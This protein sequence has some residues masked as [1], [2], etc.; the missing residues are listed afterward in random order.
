MKALRP[1]RAAALAAVLLSA[2]MLAAPLPSQAATERGLIWRVSRDG[3]PVSFLLG[4]IHVG[5]PDMYPLPETMRQAY[6]RSDALVVE[7]DIV[8]ADMGRLSS[9]V[10]EKGTYQDGGSLKDAVDPGA[11][12]DIRAAADRYG[13]PLSLLRDQKPWLAYS[14]LTLLAVQAEGYSERYGVDRHFL[15][16]A[17]KDH[18][19]VV[20][21]EGVERQLQVLADMAADQQSALLAYTAGQIADGAVP[22]AEL[23]DAWRS[24]RPAQLQAQV[25]AH[26][27]HSLQGVYDALILRRNR[28][29]V[30]RLRGL[31][32][33]RRRLLVVVG[34]AH[35]T[36][37][38]GL[39][40][41]LRQRGYRVEQM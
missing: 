37:P 3:A 41:E 20:E 23:V 30:E 28:T 38:S 7:A 18:K 9:L 5:R 19:P 40:N 33:G 36:G 12:A 1:R 13:M 32:D 17:H 29:M 8:D 39:V 2:L 6:R 35:M 21:L 10:L 16:R 4:S 26:F 25:S 11:W 27:P 31:L 14:T 22:M 34:A 24:G 15:E